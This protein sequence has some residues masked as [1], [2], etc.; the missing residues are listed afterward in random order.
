MATRIP[1]ERIGKI[2]KTVLLEI[3]KVGGEDYIRDILSIVEPKLNLGEDELIVHERIGQAKWKL[4][5]HSY[6]SKCVKA[7][8]ITKYRGLW[9]LTHQG[10]E[11][12]IK[13]DKDFIHEL[14]E[15]YRAWM[16][17]NISN[18]DE[19]KGGVVMEHPSCRGLIDWFWT[20][21]V[22]YHNRLR[23]MNTFDS[24]G[25]G[26]CQCGSEEVI[27]GSSNPKQMRAFIM[28][29]VLI[30]Q[31]MWTHFQHLY[32]DFEKTFRYPKLNSHPG[33]GM[34]PPSWLVYTRQNYD[35]KADWEVVSAISEVLLGDLYGWFRNNLWLD[36]MRS[37][38]Q[39][40]KEEI[41]NDFEEVNKD[42]LLP[43]IERIEQE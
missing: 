24:E 12:I 4:R 39:K 9:K 3:Q 16:D 2:L 13:S 42:K 17:A 38:Q 40:L 31:M 10:K 27:E 21:P 28:I 29:G 43:I 23:R 18:A 34:A 15:K 32:S 22:R 14:N 41:C 11:V 30:D 33:S 5:V 36:E 1:R 6:S 26:F 25:R 20:V 7:G 35:E 19:K 8:F 37:F